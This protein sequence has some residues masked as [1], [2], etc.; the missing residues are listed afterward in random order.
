MQV[1]PP[2]MQKTS[3]AAYCFHG[4]RMGHAIFFSVRQ[5]HASCSIHADTTWQPSPN[6]KPSS[7][8]NPGLELYQRKTSATYSLGLYSNATMPGTNCYRYT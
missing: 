1:L 6:W 3:I 2:I 8:T 7:L 4:C 5:D